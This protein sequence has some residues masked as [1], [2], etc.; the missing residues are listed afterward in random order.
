M[1]LSVGKRT[2]S[3]GDQ[4]CFFPTVVENCHG[5]EARD[6]IASENR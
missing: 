2:K 4:I 3:S 6:P 1:Y 5:T